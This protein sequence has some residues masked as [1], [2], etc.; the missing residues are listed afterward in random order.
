MICPRKAN[1]MANLI[2]VFAYVDEIEKKKKKR[3]T[4]ATTA[5]N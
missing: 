2:C 5:E 1:A 3:A 4:A